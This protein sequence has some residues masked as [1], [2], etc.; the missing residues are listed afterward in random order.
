MRSNR[1]AAAVFAALWLISLSVQADNACRTFSGNFT[2]VPAADCESPV[3]ICTHGTLTG[4]LPSTYDFT[5]DTRVPTQ[6]HD[7]FAYTG[8][9]VITTAAG[10]LI[11]KDS[12]LMR[13]NQDGSASFVT[14]VRI[15]SGTGKFKGATGGI[16]APGMLN[17]GTGST[18]GTYS[19]AICGGH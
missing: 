5:M 10:T 18:V 12:G 9:S 15:V 7:V 14:V 1:F 3:F 13:L 17:L 16:I 8:H 6:V 19:G 2:A 11:G 4:G